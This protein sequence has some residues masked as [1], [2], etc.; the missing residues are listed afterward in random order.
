[1][2][3]QDKTDNQAAL[4]AELKKFLQSGPT[5]LP[6]YFSP[7]YTEDDGVFPREVY[8]VLGD[9]VIAAKYSGIGISCARI[10]ISRL[11]TKQQVAIATKDEFYTQDGNLMSKI[12]DK[13]FL[14]VIRIFAD[15][16]QGDR[17]TEWAAQW[18]QH[19]GSLSDL[20]DLLMQTWLNDKI[21]IENVFDIIRANDAS[22]LLKSFRLE[23]EKY[24]K[25]DHNNKP[26]CVQKVDYLDFLIQ[27]QTMLTEKVSPT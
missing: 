18:T 6:S 1:M 17:F 25:C 15:K 5:E 24:N 19:D 13:A 23:I 14:D 4:V 16:G 20:K 7:L 10:I 26:A 9:I 11:S 27:S 22:S 2:N 12:N 3:K 8:D 21:T